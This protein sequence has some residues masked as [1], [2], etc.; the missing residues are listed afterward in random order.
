MGMSVTSEC[1]CHSAFSMGYNYPQNC[2]HMVSCI[3]PSAQPKQHLDQI[4]R[5]S[6]AGRVLSPHLINAFAQGFNLTDGSF[7]PPKWHLDRCIR[8]CRAH[9]C[10]QQTHK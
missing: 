3:H 1:Q 6:T 2:P 5:F 4:S 8:F 9:G 10:D 7:R